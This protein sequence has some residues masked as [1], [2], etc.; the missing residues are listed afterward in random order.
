MGAERNS[1]ISFQRAAESVIQ[2]V[3]TIEAN[4]RTISNG[5]A[6]GIEPCNNP[7]TH[8]DFSLLAHLLDS[9]FDSKAPAATLPS[10]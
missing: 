1:V 7:L 5:W 2:N 10:L 6:G 9:I 4:R 8:K 3:A